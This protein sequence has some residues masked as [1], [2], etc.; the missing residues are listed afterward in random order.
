M[1]I[2]A[3]ESFLA[4]TYLLVRIRTDS[5]LSG[6]GQAAYFS[7]PEAS[8]QVVQRYATYLVGRD[9]LQ[10]ERHWYTLF[11]S[12]PFRGADQMGALSAVD[13]ALWDL[14]GK[15]FQ[16][17][18]YQLMG[19]RQRDKVRLHYLMAGSSEAEVDALVERA[20]F[21]AGEGFTALKLDPLPP[22][23]QRLSQSRVIEETVQR[24]AAVRE[25]V[26]WD[27]DIGVEV[28]RKLVPGDA[29]ALAGYL[30]PF[31]ILFYEDPIRPLSMEAHAEVARKVRIPIAIGERHHTI[32]EF[33]D[34]LATGSIQYVRH[35]VG[36]AGGL[37]HGKKIA[38]LAEAF[39]A[40]VI[41]H[42]FISPLLT[43]AS[44]QLDLAIPN[45]TLQ[46]YC[47]WDEEAPARDLV[48]APLQREGGYLLPPEQ[49]GLG[50]EVDE[51]F[52]QQYPFKAGTPGAPL[53]EDGSVALH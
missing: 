19:G 25:T 12:S 40:G 22:M 45:C 3:V 26:G 44:V 23:H 15:H 24:V 43:A 7:Y 27:M 2:E 38:T 20:R 13:I 31:R 53:H 36:L 30:E 11:G 29:I 6:W 49:P 35:D 48:K 5:G 46:E 50:V 41:T 9:P 28:H 42:N 39:H 16:V 37:S 4:H 52:L 33:R 17:P 21:A 8:Q 14:A 18:A 32:H 10:I 51:T 34:L 1:K 47:M